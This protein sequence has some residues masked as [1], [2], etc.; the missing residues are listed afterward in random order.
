MLGEWF[1]SS[2]ASRLVDKLW[3]YVASV[4][5][6]QLIDTKEKLKQLEN[7]LKVI[8]A[9]I[10]VAEA[11]RFNSPP[12][13]EQLAAFKNAAYELDDIL[14]KFDYR[15]LEDK[16]SNVNKLQVRGL[17]RSSFYLPP[18]AKRARKLF[19]R[20]LFSDE[21]LNELMAALKKFDRV[22]DDISTLVKLL[23][24]SPKQD[25]SLDWRQTTSISESK[26]F[27]RDNEKESL[28]NLLI[29]TSDSFSSSTSKFSVVSLVGMGGVGKTTLAQAAY[30]DPSVTSYFDLKAWVC[31][32]HK[33]DVR[34]ITIQIIE[35]GSIRSR[36]N[37]HNI[38][39]LSR[40]QSFLTKGLR[41]KKFLIVLDDV[42]N[43]VSSK[44][45]ILSRPFQ[46]AKEGSI[47]LV[48]SRNQRIA[49]IM[50]AKETMKLEGLR[51]EDYL[52]FFMK[53]AFGSHNSCDHPK[54]QNIGRQIAK[55]MGGSPLAAKTVGAALKFNLEEE[56]WRKILASKLWQ[57]H[58]NEDGILPALRLSYEHL[59][60]Q[61]KQCFTYCSIFPKNHSFEKDSLVLMWMALGLV[62]PNGQRRL[63]D[64]AG[65]Y[66]DDLLSRFFFQNAVG[67]EERFVIHDL[68]HDLA[69]SVPTGD[70]FRIEN[71]LVVEVPRGVNH[72]YVNATNLLKVYEFRSEMKSLRS[73]VLFEDQPLAM[74][75]FNHV[76]E[77]VLK[78]LKGLRVL[79]LHDL[80]LTNLPEAIGNSVHL[81][82]LEIQSSN[83]IKFP[84]SL[85]R[86]YHLQV[87]NLKKSNRVNSH[88]WPLKPNPEAIKDL[89]SLRYLRINPQ[90]FTSIPGIA[91][92]TCL[93]E[94]DQ[95][96]V[97]K[98]RGFKIDE[99]GKL[100]QL[101]GRLCIKNLEN[102]NSEMEAREAKLDEKEHLKKLSLYWNY[103]GQ[104]CMSTYK[105]ED[106][107]EGLQPH[108]NLIELKIRRYMGTKSP[109]WLENKSW[110]SNLER[111]ELSN[112][113][114]WKLL[115]PLGQL[116]FLRFLQLSRMKSVEQLGA[117]FYG[118]YV[119]AFPSLEELRIGDMPELKEWL[120]IESF[121]DLFP[122]LAKLHI[123][124]CR[125]LRGPFPTPT[126]RK[127]IAMFLSDKI[128]PIADG[129]RRMCKKKEEMLEFY[130]DRIWR[131]SQCIPAAKLDLLRHLEISS[132]FLVAFTVEQEEW[133]MLLK[134]LRCL[135][136]LE[137]N[138]MSSLPTVLKWLT[139]LQRIQV[140]RCPNLKS[141]PENGLPAELK[142]LHISKCHKELN[143]RC[144]WKNG[145]DWHKISHVETITIDAEDGRRNH[146]TYHPIG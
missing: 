32:S 125:K 33:F 137:C 18:A 126:S 48:T 81:R 120:S 34:S 112:C 57:V 62:Q 42:W 28:V 47:V 36:K 122:S 143:E 99:L 58:Q 95:F 92:L 68:L 14:D 103:V 80:P 39:S 104:G 1:A 53:C 142:E 11:S 123:R 89:I 5:E 135:S 23:D 131:V 19:E 73:L 105:D 55:K 17:F 66:F 74:S 101:H 21:D 27:G 118:S 96:H 139:S 145:A 49:D 113:D 124:N 69:E 38:R 3:C 116:P 146:S 30:N 85:S 79:V 121:R 128:T 71:D 16:V 140:M 75:T 83:A 9:A 91:S 82:Y 109:R 45:S 130:T 7:K 40:I 133:F 22:S 78:E 20:W 29:G 59:P 94:L 86:L 72:L 117:D 76:F 63:E 106:I 119:A 70:H 88:Y 15:V 6:Y 61:L 111:I 77:E 37:F 144:S 127:E 84:K 60:V 2:F 67:S 43:E 114:N 93:Q 51:D 115:P 87:L 136:F 4:Y 50:E 54:L 44:W 24:L 102:V 141:L 13:A 107:L 65:E 134:C 110:G 46:S 52:S 12:L 26:L 132:C 138:S 97:K 41:Q 129:K 31:V 100:K 35:S 10:D 64:I 25:E 98:A 108:P 56:H 90:S 8:H